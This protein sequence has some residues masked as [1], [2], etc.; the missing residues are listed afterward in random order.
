MT[1]IGTCMNRSSLSLIAILLVSG[2]I[3]GCTGVV[4][5]G[6][7]A[8]AT[9][10]H[11]RRTLGVY[12]EDQTIE[13]KAAEAIA[14]DPEFRDNS[15]INITS[16]NMVVLLT[17]QTANQ[18]LKQRAE[19]LVAKV[20]RVRRVVNELEIG[21]TASLGER[22]R[23]AAL[24]AEIKFK[25]TNI[26]I[27]DFDPLRVKVVAER[28]NVYLLG[29]LTRDEGNAVTELV[30]QISGVRKVVKVFEYY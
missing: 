6:A 24:V 16:Y 2:L 21:S 13:F 28:G 15:R 26:D 9:I 4:I 7:A 14:A 5:G 1:T 18:A 3:Q 30:R 20:E 8:T 11:D 22:T 12:V 17:G 27:P 10:I 29:L 19:Q 23:S 25:L